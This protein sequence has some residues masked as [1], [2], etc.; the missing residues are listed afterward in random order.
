MAR[1]S[2]MT[3]NIAM[4]TSNLETR[5][6]LIRFSWTQAAQPSRKTTDSKP[7]PPWQPTTH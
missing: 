7:Q 4:Q 1:P 3:W 6:L 2:I 5:N